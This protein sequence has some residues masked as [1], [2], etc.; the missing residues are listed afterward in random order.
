MKNLT[1]CML[2][3]VLMLA[4]AVSASAQAPRETR[5]LVTVVDSTGGILQGASVRVAGQD[6]ATQAAVT[7][8]AVATEK[9]LATVAALK[10]GTT[11]SMWKWTVSSRARSRTCVLRPGDNKHVVVLELKKLEQA[12]TVSRDAVAAASDPHGGSLTT[13]L[14][15][16]EI[17]ALSDDPNEMMQQLQDMA[18]GNAVIKIDSFVGG[19]LP[20]KAF[21]KSIHIVARHVPG[22]ESLGGKRRRSTS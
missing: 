4:G 18:G 6:E 17:N 14:T 8:S 22:R 21:I 10:P 7:G 3:T 13:Q 16:Q 11:K 19:A 1:S 20:P 2:S 12:V 15:T 9:G 5:L